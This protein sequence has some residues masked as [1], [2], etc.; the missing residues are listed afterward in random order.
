[1]K[2]VKGTKKWK[3]ILYPR[4][5]KIVLLKCTSYPK[6]STH[7][8]AISVKIAHDIFHRTTTTNPRIDMKP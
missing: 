2:E 6:Q 1:M 5:E 3:D 7:F 4:L 8:N